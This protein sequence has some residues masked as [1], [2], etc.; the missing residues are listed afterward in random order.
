MNKSPSAAWK[1]I[2]AI[3]LLIQAVT[4]ACALG[5]IWE[6]DDLTEVSP[7]GPPLDVDSKGD[8]QDKTTKEQPAKGPVGSD[9]TK[10]LSSPIV[11]SS[12]S[13]PVVTTSASTP[14][15][16]PT[17]S[18]SGSTTTVSGSTITSTGSAPLVV[19]TATNSTTLPTENRVV[20]KTDDV[21]KRTPL[22]L[23]RVLHI[24]HPTSEQKILWIVFIAGA[25]GAAV[26]ALASFLT[27]MGNDKLTTSWLGW[28]LGRAPIGGGLGVIVYFTLRAGLM[29]STANSEKNLNVFGFAA[30]SLLTGMFNRHAL[31]KL[32]KVAEAVF[33]SPHEE[34]N[35]LGNAGITIDKFEP[36]KI[37]VGTVTPQPVT[38][39]GTGFGASDFVLVDGEYY[40][41]TSISDTQLKFVLDQKQM[42]AIAKLSV[43]VVHPGPNGKMSLPPKELAIVAA[44]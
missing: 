43:Q 2:V 15:A 31:A 20:E 5:H 33:T 16:A 26:H 32:V 7:K 25:L 44:P 23:Y 1:W 11:S 35:N 6:P 10:T 8:K 24:D 34:A 39:I 37:T 36:E 19:S 22:L 9:N 14:L 3:L 4:L 42:G 30:M 17:V 40:K 29:S 38:L 28:Y 13:A 41:P 21:P 12:N 27:Y 18:A